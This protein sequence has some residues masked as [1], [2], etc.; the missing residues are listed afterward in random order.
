MDLN[1]LKIELTHAITAELARRQKSD[2]DMVR[3]YAVSFMESGTDEDRASYLR[4]RAKAETMELAINV[5]QDAS[6]DFTFEGDSDE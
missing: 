1:R 4:H 6:R 5:A 2:E 3:H